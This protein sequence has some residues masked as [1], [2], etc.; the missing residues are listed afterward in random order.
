[1]DPNNLHLEWYTFFSWWA[2]IWFLIY[3]IGFIPFSPFMLYVFIIIYIIYKIGLIFYDFYKNRNEIKKKVK[4]YNYGVLV[5]WFLI[6]F[7]IDILPFLLLKRVINK[8]SLLFTVI[9]IFIYCL[10]M[11]YLNIN[12]YQHYRTVYSR[13]M[14]MSNNHN[15]IELFRKVFTT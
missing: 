5:S 6:V 3:K 12:I 2:F 9:L 13:I 7:I 14:Y 10:M 15:T 4:K 1:M 11:N 8:E